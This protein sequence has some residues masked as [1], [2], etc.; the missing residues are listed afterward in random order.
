MSNPLITTGSYNKTNLEILK[1]GI[2]EN[3]NTANANRDLLLLYSNPFTY[4]GTTQPGI[5]SKLVFLSKPC[6]PTFYF[7]LSEKIKTQDFV[8]QKELICRMI[9]SGRGFKFSR[10]NPDTTTEPERKNEMN[11]SKE[12]RPTF[13]LRFCI[14]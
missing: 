8:R 5:E 3:L 9:I 12:K 11:G 1:A 14:P 4:I 7:F 13:C 10:E 6:N 2:S